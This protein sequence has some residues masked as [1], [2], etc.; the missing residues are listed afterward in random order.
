MAAPKL[1]IPDKDLESF[2]DRHHIRKL[3]LFG[4]IL[5]PQF[6]DDSDI[7]VLIEFESGRTPDLL[8]YAGMQTELSEML[9]RQVDLRTAHMLSRY[10]RDEVVASSVVQYER[11]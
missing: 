3:S 1:P 5:T 10:F 11:S 7:D 2:C 4:S 8:T 9:G 6:H